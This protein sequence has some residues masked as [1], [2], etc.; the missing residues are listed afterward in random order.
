[1]VH[2][3]RIIPLDNSPHLTPRVRQWMGD[4][5]GH[6]EGDTLVID[7]TN[8]TD[9]TNFRGSTAGLHM[10]E[11]IS[12]VD[13]DTLNYEV[14]FDDPTTWTRPWTAANMWRTSRGQIY[15][16]ACHEGNYGMFGI[17]SGGRKEDKDAR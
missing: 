14:T 15:E 11:H 17:L 1:M 10:I 4:S 7:T 8:F 5:R 6:W 3:V 16:Y 12:R 9:K 2:E 13:A